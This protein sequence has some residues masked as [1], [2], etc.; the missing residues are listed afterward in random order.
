VSAGFLFVGAVA[1]GVGDS[2]MFQYVK[3]EPPGLADNLALDRLGNN[4]YQAVSRLDFRGDPCAL[5]PQD[6][7]ETSFPFLVRLDR[8]GCV[9]SRTHVAAHL[10]MLSR[11]S[12][13]A[14]GH[15]PFV[16]FTL[17]DH[18]DGLDAARW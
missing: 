7:E 18:G 12:F 10:A 3:S 4:R 15:D 1:G 14:I 9:L 8:L 2:P 17:I 13:P 6:A 16:G 5:L 11:L